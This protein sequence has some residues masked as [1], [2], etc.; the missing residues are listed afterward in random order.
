MD[1]Y[2]THKTVSKGTV[3]HGYSNPKPVPVLGHTHNWI[4]TVLPG[5]VSCL[6]YNSSIV[7]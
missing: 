2:N 3:L 7:C 6:T 5:P 1:V 4:S